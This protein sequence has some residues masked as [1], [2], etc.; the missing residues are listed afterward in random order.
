[1]VCYLGLGSNL[2]D[3][4]NYINRAISRLSSHAEISLLKCSTII[5]T[6]PY[7]KV[8][9]PDF[10]NCVMKIKTHLT[11]QKILKLC[12]KIEKSL[13]RMRFETWGPRTIDI[14]LLLYG[15]EIIDEP[16]L[17]V[18][19]PEIPKRKFVLKSLVELSPEFVH[20][21]TGRTFRELYADLNKK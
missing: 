2:G 15:K 13:G 9:Q 12:L 20:P 21:I 18:P 3:R 17:Q 1:M 5:E 6:E 8:D 16:E 4:K 7:G 10:L 11:P 14:D 19:H